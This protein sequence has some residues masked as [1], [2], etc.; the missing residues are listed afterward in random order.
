VGAL[1]RPVIHRKGGLRPEH[2]YRTAALL[3]LLAVLFHY[4]ESIVHVLLMAYA[5]V[6][7]AVLFNALIRK[8]PL[9]RKWMAGLLG[10]L[11][12]AGIFAL[13]WFGIPILADQIRALVRRIPELGALLTDVEGWLRTSTGINVNLVSSD[14][15]EFFRD[16]FLGTSGGGG[17]ILA[18]A[19]GLLEYLLLPVLILMGALFAVG[20]PNG[21]LLLP[22]LRAVPRELRPSFRRMFALLGERLLGW[23]E[24]V[25]LGMVA[26]GMLSFFGYW[27][28]GVPNPLA[29][30]VIAGLTEAIPLLGPWIGGSIA[31]AVGFLESPQTGLYA[32]LVAF[33]IQQIEGNLIIPWAMSRTTRVHPF[34]T[35]FSLVLFGTLFG[36][37]GVLLSIPIVLLVGT[38]VQVFWVDRAIHA[39]RDRIEPITDR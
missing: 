8:V 32:A 28:V 35:L 18:Q 5:A 37:L 10:L 31:A 22:V 21:G 2:L 16:A 15:R 17:G 25:L 11:I 7:L 3:F 23:V 13:L 39:Q 9:E 26:V 19:R 4:L 30:A 36:F 29:L 20:K 27:L 33:A 14:V 1:N 38:A 24:G 34:V 6:I 12:V